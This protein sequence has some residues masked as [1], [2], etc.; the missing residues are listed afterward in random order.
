MSFIEFI[1]KKVTLYLEDGH[2]IKG[3]VVNTSCLET[4]DSCGGCVKYETL[5]LVL[6]NEHTTIVRS[7]K[8]VAIEIH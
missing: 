5:V 8:I 1:G 7:D 4:T 2:V 3:Y 6:K